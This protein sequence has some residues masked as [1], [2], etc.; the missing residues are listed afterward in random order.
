MEL[1]VAR[2]TIGRYHVYFICFSW[3]AQPPVVVK[4]ASFSVEREN[5]LMHVCVICVFKCVFIF[6]C[7]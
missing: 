1:A 5:E 7:G 3:P 2:M 6:Q 4:V